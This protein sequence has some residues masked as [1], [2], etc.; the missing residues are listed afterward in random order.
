MFKASEIAGSAWKIGFS[1]VCR[2]GSPV[3]RIGVCRTGYSSLFRT[4]GS[5]ICMTGFSPVCRTGSSPVCRTGSSPVCRIGSSPVCIGLVVKGTVH[6]SNTW[7]KSLANGSLIL[8]S[9]KSIIFGS[10]VILL[11]SIIF[12]FGS[13][14]IILGSI[15]II[16][17]SFIAFLSNLCCG[18]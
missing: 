11:G 7:A 6:A 12:I 15:I 13:I 4:G 5:L 14:I 9:Y 3:F 1:L 17:G 16:L 10:I 2:T 18:F 8:V